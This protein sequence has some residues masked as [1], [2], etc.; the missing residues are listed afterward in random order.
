MIVM[1]CQANL[2][3]VAL[4]TNPVRGLADFL[5][6]RQQQAHYDCDDGDYDQ[7]F[8]QRKSLTELFRMLHVDLLD[9]IKTCSRSVGT[10]DRSLVVSASTA[11]KPIPLLA[12]D[13]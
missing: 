9:K 1:Q 2:P 10:S 5:D 4:A 6:G 13:R 7:Q 8:Q 11:K 12:I 3:K